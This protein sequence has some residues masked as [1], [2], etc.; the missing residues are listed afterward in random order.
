MI[1]YMIL[2][3][4]LLFLGITLFVLM[5]HYKKNKVA[6]RTITYFLCS[7]F[8]AFF[9]ILAG[10]VEKE[11]ITIQSIANYWK[12]ALDMFGFKFGIDDTILN[13]FLLKDT[14]KNVANILFIIGYCLSFIACAFTSISAITAIF[15]RFL[16]NQIRVRLAF[17]HDLDI[18]I[19]PKLPSDSY[20]NDLVKNKRKMLLL[21]TYPLSDEEKKILSEQRLPFI[22]YE[23]V[24]LALEF[25]FNR[26]KK[27]NHHYCFIYYEEEENTRFKFLV[28]YIDWMKKIEEKQKIAFNKFRERMALYISFTKDYYSSVDDLFGI[29]VIAYQIHLFNKYEI[30]SKDFQLRYPFVHV[31]EEGDIVSG[32]LKE[33]I[34]PKIIFV[35]FG[36]VNQE[37][38]KGAVINNQFV[39]FSKKEKKLCAAPITY[40]AFDKDNSEKKDKSATYLYRFFKEKKGDFEVAEV[41]YLVGDFQNMEAN[42]EWNAYTE[43]FIKELQKILQPSK[44]GNEVRAQILISLAHDMNDLD[45]GMKILRFISLDENLKKHVQVYVR[46]K[47]SQMQEQVQKLGLLHYYGQDELLTHDHIVDEKLSFLQEKTHSLYA[48]YSFET[49]LSTFKLWKDREPIQFRRNAYESLNDIVK[50]YILGFKVSYS[51]SQ[52]ENIPFSTFLSH[53]FKNSNQY[54]PLF[55]EN[56]AMKDQ[57]AL[58]EITKQYLD[59][60]TQD[61]EDEKDDA[62]TLYALG[63]QEKLRW[64]AFLIMN[65]YAM[66]NKKDIRIELNRQEDNSFTF[67]NANSSYKVAYFYQNQ[68]A[69][70]SYYINLKEHACLTSVRGLEAYHIYLASLIQKRLEALQND[71]K[72]E[73]YILLL[74]KKWLGHDAE[75]ELLSST[76]F[77]L[78]EKEYTLESYL[79]ELS[80]SL[81]DTYKYDLNNILNLYQKY[82][83]NSHF[84]IEEINK[85]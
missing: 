61:K 75:I 3:M 43:G 18:V 81:A 55:D 11:T 22:E 83:T 80:H 25:I 37:I 5:Y 39:K 31:L 50:L 34:E 40:Y 45:L 35:G 17:H 51:S 30:F 70:K 7:L 64:N 65:G 14:S 29:D 79:K 56:Y 78:N 4:V 66:M 59:F 68:P 8:A 60:L 69:E 44:E 26:I 71:T 28:N 62:F 53:L 77:K 52:K 46:M 38:F 1:L 63:Y 36:H 54:L 27:N 76:T 72:L 49:G 19:N 23:D 13:I 20:V 47:S 82:F 84:T 85:E 48:K 12:T 74:E 10:H 16:G 21:F 9:F 2:G 73:D 67:I 32:C 6:L 24:A 57:D 15:F 58:T 42:Q 41:P 33:N